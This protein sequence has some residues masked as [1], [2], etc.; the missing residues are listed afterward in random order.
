M[1]SA[2][3]AFITEPNEIAEADY[4]RDGERRRAGS[5]SIGEKV[6]ERK[7]RGK[8]KEEE[9]EEGD[10]AWLYFPKTPNNVCVCVCECL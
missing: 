3:I 9:E 6:K 4:P 10:T 7:K 8:K 1:K 2:G 5:L